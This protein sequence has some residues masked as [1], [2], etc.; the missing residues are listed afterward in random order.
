M[1]AD[2]FKK[3]I[4]LTPT[5]ADAHYRYGVTLLSQAKRIGHR[6]K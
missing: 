2:A 1:A 6:A 3:A 5:Y 4:E